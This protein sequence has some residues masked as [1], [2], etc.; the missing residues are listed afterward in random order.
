MLSA[1]IARLSKDDGTDAIA[2]GDPTQGKGLG[3]ALAEGRGRDEAK[4]E[5]GIM[6]SVGVVAGAE[7]R[8]CAEAGSEDEG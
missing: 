6:A 4:A 1:T 3:K 7:G 5:G 8:G 2:M